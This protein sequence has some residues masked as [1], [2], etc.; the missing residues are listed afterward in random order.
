MMLLFLAVLPFASQALPCYTGTIT[1]RDQ[2][3]TKD[4]LM[5][6][7]GPVLGASML[8][9]IN[10]NPKLKAFMDTRG[11]C[12]HDC[13]GPMMEQTFSTL[14]GKLGKD[15]FKE[16]NKKIVIEGLT[17]AFRACYPSP[18]R[19]EIYK[20]AKMVINGMGKPAAEDQAL[21]EGT[22]CPNDGHEDD[23]PMKQV[24][25][26]F[27]NAFEG[28]VSKNKRAMKFFQEKA[29]DCQFHCLETTVSLSMKTLF[30]TDQQD[31]QIGAEAI[32]GAMHACFPGIPSGEIE[33]MVK[34]TVEV[35]QHAQEVAT[36]RLYTTNM[37]KLASSYSFFPLCGLVMAM[38]LMLFSAG[39]A[40]GR[41][42]K[43]SSYREVEEGQQETLIVA[44]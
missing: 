4:D 21:P 42:W 8:S 27:G 1:V 32:T 28:V 44:E 5:K 15:F 18:P 16:D 41:R 39:A 20:L 37:M 36:T 17:G 12:Q 6:L 35:L 38:G 14:Y 10:E 3:L 29:K 31:D 19:H 2:E 26:E 7:I 40:V 24:L 43:R 23:F 11:Q 30:L 13:L 22:T 33:S 25:E 34:Q 9:T